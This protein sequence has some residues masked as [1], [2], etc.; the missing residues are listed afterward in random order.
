MTILQ[1]EHPVVDFDAWKAT[2]AGD[3]T[4]RRESGMRS[5]RILR[6]LDDPK[7]VII[8]CEFASSAEAEAFLAKMREAWKRVVGKII[9]R[10]QG[11]ISVV[12]EI[13]HY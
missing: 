6:P 10:P 8:D 5:Y 12:T 4:K 7:Y 1:I 2:F 3:P 13:R 9:E 11:R